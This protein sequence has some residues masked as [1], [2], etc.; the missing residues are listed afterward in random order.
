MVLGGAMCR[1]TFDDGLT[2]GAVP[3]RPQVANPMGKT[4]GRCASN[5]LNQS[6]C[7]VGGQVRTCNRRSVGAECESVTVIDA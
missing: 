5:A 6:G 3:Y 1:S 7:S 2:Y 4:C